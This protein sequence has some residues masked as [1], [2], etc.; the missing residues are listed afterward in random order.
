MS[1]INEILSHYST[2]GKEGLIEKSKDR[3]GVSTKFEYDVQHRVTKI[4]RGYST[5]TLTD[6][7]SIAFNQMIPQASPAEFGT[8]KISPLQSQ[9][10]KDTSAAIKAT[11]LQ[12]ELKTNQFATVALFDLSALITSHKSSTA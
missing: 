10:T 11:T 3:N 7:A 1:N 9:M 4:T 12:T 5:I 6:I 2:A 8:R